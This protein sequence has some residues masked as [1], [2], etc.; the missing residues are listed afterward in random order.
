MVYRSMYP[1]FAVF[2]KYIF[3]RNSSNIFNN[4]QYNKKDFWN[5]LCTMNGYPLFDVDEDERQINKEK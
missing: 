1:C 2:R 5:M 3:K 4:G